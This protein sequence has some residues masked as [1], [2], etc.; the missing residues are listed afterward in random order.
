MR[1]LVLVGAALLVLSLAACS[2]APE[3]IEPS[4]AA[5]SAPRPR[6][7]LTPPPLPKQAERKDATGAANFVLY[8][9]KAY[10]YAAS[11]GDTYAMRDH[12]SE[13]DVCVGYADDFDALRPSQLLQGDAWK[14]TNIKQSKT[15]EGY[16]IDADVSAY[17]ESHI[18]K[19]TFV[20]RH[21]D[22]Y[23]LVHIYER[24]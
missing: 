24:P 15:D 22:P 7:T 6:S 5:S 18:Y 19:L 2:G 1:R 12:S 23:E 20:V 13:C 11:T 16:Q 4:A 17:G 14:L 9:V 10:N 3:P 8:W 21:A